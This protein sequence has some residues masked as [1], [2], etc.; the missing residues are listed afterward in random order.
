MCFQAFSARLP[1]GCD[2]QKIASI[3]CHFSLCLIQRLFVIDVEVSELMKEAGV[4][5]P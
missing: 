3:E 5:F 1:L 4:E 2:T